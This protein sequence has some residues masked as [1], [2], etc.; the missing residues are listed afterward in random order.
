MHAIN[1]EKHTCIEE[2]FKDIQ[3]SSVVLLQNLYVA[4]VGEDSLKDLT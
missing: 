4:S 3:N 1:V 2:V